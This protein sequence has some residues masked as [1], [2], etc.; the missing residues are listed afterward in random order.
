MICPQC[1]GAQLASEF[2]PGGISFRCLADGCGCQFKDNPSLDFSDDAPA[3][4]LAPAKTIAAPPKFAAPAPVAES[5]RPRDVL[6]LARKRLAEL[7]R[8]IKKLKAL[9]S[10][11]D[12]IKRLLAAANQSTDGQANV[13]PLRTKT[14]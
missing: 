8:E 2:G 4:A 3:P 13:R 12:Q 6:R 7:N 5:L 11:R 10:E 9:T 14:G 1:Q